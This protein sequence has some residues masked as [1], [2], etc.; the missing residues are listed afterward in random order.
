M[1]VI[2]SSTPY[3]RNGLNTANPFRQPCAKLLSERC[4]AFP[5]H[6]GAVLFPVLRNAGC[7]ENILL[8]SRKTL[9]SD[10]SRIILLW[11]LKFVCASRQNAFTAF[12]MSWCDAPAI[13]IGRRVS[14]SRESSRHMLP[15]TQRRL[16][17]FSRHVARVL[18][19]YAEQ[20]SASSPAPL[21]RTQ[22]LN[23][24]PFRGL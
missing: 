14:S 20:P 5:T 24:P 15:L 4:P 2:A 7:S 9:R 21:A 10:L 12:T 18:G 13:A 1:A 11:S 22:L 16:T 6:A 23:K 8:S 3:S 19:D 17:Q